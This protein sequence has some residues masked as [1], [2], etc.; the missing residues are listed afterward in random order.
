MPLVPDIVRYASEQH[1]RRG[2]TIDQPKEQQNIAAHF[3]ELGLDEAHIL[4]SLEAM[5]PP[6][7][8]VARGVW[9]LTPLHPMKLCVF[10]DRIIFIRRW[11]W[12]RRLFR[13]ERAVMLAHIREVESDFGILSATVIFRTY[14]GVVLLSAQKMH[15]KEAR[16]AT[17]VIQA[18]L[19]DEL[20]SNLRERME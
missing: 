7:L 5:A 6:C 19:H 3:L 12:F 2:H 8:C 11:L 17:R 13:C 15:K 14:R 16:K 20:H 18:L 1:I 9:W 10:S 4:P